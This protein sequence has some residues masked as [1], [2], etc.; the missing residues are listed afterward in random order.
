MELTGTLRRTLSLLQPRER[1]TG[2]AVV[3][4]MF[5]VALLE[6]AGV[7]SIMPFLAVLADPGVVETNQTL[8][9]LH[10]AVGSP[11]ADTFLM[12]LG[13]A[14]FLLVV[15]GGVLRIGTTYAIHRY[16]QMRRY[17]I[18]TRLLEA[19][20][21]Q[22]YEF[23]LRR[24]TGDLSRSV[25]SEV[26]NLVLQLLRPGMEMVANGMVV[27]LLLVL[28]FV[29][30][31]VLAIATMV[32]VGGGYGALYLSVRGFLQRTGRDRVA[33]NRE[34]FV[35]VGE[36][37]GGIKDLKIYGGERTYLQRFRGPAARFARHMARAL[38]LSQAPKYLLEAIG[39]GTILVL[40]LVLVRI[41]QDAGEIVPL[42]GLYAFAGYRILPAAQ[43]VYAGASSIRFGRSALDS[44]YQDFAAR[45]VGG[46]DAVRSRTPV[47]LTREIRFD[48]VSYR[49]PESEHDSVR[50]VTVAIPVGKLVAL[51]G[52]TGAGKT[53]LADLLMGLL[54][55]THGQ[56]LLDGH[57]MTGSAIGAWRASIGYVPQEIYLVDGT[58]AENIAF[59]VEPDRID[60]AAMERAARAARIHDFI[61]SRLPDGYA[62]HVGERGV[63]LS[64]GQRQRLGIARAL[65]HDPAVLVL[66]EATSALDTVTDRAVLESIAGLR[67]RKTVIIVAHRMSSVRMCD[68]VLLMEAGKLIGADRY[69]S[70]METNPIFREMGRI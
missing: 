58:V 67:G 60:P 22:P 41:R 50:S 37:F 15:A 14:A 13:L 11:P 23:F 52:P 4:L 54:Q 25:L 9:S 51:T 49:Y 66:D 31:P 40:A 59:G 65:Y 10:R 27:V 21:R 38:T 63:R 12:A 6:T 35:A 8:Q 68:L 64:G 32:A 30:D 70:L 19:Y 56:I 42:L 16:S 18:A 45:A 20:L 17:T 47:E 61:L 1:R 39:F 69:E 34:R 36:L 28:L 48:G 3:G 46:S 5:M 57:P 26:D 24:H 33:A 55:P 29:V 7:L 43:R 2:V 44:V 53:T 62:S